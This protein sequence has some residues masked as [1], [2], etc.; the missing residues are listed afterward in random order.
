MK[1][2]F[3]VFSNDEVLSDSYPITVEHE[4]VVLEVASRVIVKGNEQFDIGRGNE[5]GGGAEEEAVEDTAERVN[6]IIAAFNLQEVPFTKKEYT[7]Y[8]RGYMQR[9]KKH[10]E[11]S[12]PDRVATFMAGASAFVKRVLANFNEFKFYVG[13]SYDQTAGVILSYFKEESNEAPHFLYIRDGLR[14]EKF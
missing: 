7:V 2:Y 8:I 10:L 5:F 11:E 9:L 12:N 6:E 14:E 13:S 4:D 3:D 1:V